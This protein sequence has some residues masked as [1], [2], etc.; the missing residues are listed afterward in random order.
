MYILPEHMILYLRENNFN[1]LH[2]ITCFNRN[3]IRGEGWLSAAEVDFEGEDRLIWDDYV[4]ILNNSNVHIQ[5]CSD[6]LIWMHSPT[7][8]YSPKHAYRFLIQEIVSGEDWWWW[9]V[10]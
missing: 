9:R 5:V 7:G 10:V 8:V 4:A 2:S 3:T 6:R 1:T